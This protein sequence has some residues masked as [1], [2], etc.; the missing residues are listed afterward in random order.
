MKLEEL[1]IF[2]ESKG[3]KCE[4]ISIL[5]ETSAKLKFLTE[6]EAIRAFYSL[7]YTK[8]ENSYIILSQQMIIKSLP[9][10]ANLYVKN[11]KP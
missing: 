1:K 9:F 2:I 6:D 3:F 11:L 8:I 7:N 4:N 10:G 5:N